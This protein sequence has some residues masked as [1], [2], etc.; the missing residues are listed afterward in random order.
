MEVCV[1]EVFDKDEPGYLR[2]AETNQRKGSS[3]IQTT[4]REALYTR[5]FTAPRIGHLR[6]REEVTSRQDRAFSR[7]AQQALGT[8]NAGRGAKETDRLLDA[9][10]ACELNDT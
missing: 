7:F 4:M 3:S 2:W 5:W 9:L 6:A 10:F 8:L 1:E